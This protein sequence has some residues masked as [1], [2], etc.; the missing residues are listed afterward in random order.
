MQHFLI[1]IIVG[2]AA[3][4]IIRRYYRSFKSSKTD[5]CSCGCTSCG[6]ASS[7]DQISEISGKD[8]K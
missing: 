6:S 5:P 3:G 4:Y 8:E 1:L 2:L 7:C